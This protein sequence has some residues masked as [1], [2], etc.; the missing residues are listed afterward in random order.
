MLVSYE[1]LLKEAT[2]QLKKA[3]IA[4]Y[5]LDAWYLMEEAFSI[6]RVFYLLHKKDIV[7]GREK[8]ILDYNTMIERRVRRIPLQ[9]I[10]GKQEFMGFSFL[11]NEYVLI[12]RQDTEVL[13]EAVLKENKDKNLSVL[14][15]C[16]GSGCIAISLALLG[17]YRHV[18]GSDFSVQ[19][20]ETAKK[21]NEVLHAGV[22]FYT[23]DLFEHVEGFYDII[24]SNPP[25]IEKDVIATLEPEVKDH[26]PYSA[27]YG[28]QKGLYFYRAIAKEAKKKIKCRWKFIF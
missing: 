19:A 9:H 18:E 15:M 4:E 16:T 1:T 8:N 7:V 24:V 20:V 21:N 28:P 13:V 23:G 3:G 26:E 6:D 11:V 27:L 5:E 17:K 14:D 12:P 25:Y 22:T 2:E 10:I